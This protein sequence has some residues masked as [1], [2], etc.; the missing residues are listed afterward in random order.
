MFHKATN[1][2]AKNPLF[3]RF[4]GTPQPTVKTATTY[5]E[6][7]RARQQTQTT[8]TIQLDEKFYLSDS[9][10]NGEWEQGFFKDINGIP[11]GFVKI[12]N[13]EEKTINGTKILEG[14]IL[15]DMEV[16]PIARGQ[17]APLEILRQ[18]KKHYN[19][20]HIWVGDTY[21]DK[22]L[23]MFHRL[24]QHEKQTG[25]VTLKLKPYHKEEQLRGGHPEYSFVQNWDTLQPKYPL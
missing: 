8:T 6:Y 16:N 20:E 15:C 14:I 13:T 7:E 11:I 9:K 24:R 22:G 23:K 25:E 1:C 3:C 4:H 19:V 21:S 10:G 17:N 12:R 5:E 18:L 2:K